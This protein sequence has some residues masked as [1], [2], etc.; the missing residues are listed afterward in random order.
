[1]Y[2]LAHVIQ[3]SNRRVVVLAWM[4]RVPEE[5]VQLVEAKVP[6]AM[7]ILA[8]YSVLLKKLEYLWWHR[9][10]AQ[11][12]LS[13]LRDELGTDSNQNLYECLCWPIEEVL[14]KSEDTA[15]ERLRV[16]T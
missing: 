13:V 10:I 16:H 8:S 2:S 4:S 5:F 14:R 11:T 15:K 3:G 1:M 6:E 12:L 7:L 9:G